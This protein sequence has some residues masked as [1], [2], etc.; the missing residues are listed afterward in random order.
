M[1][2]M[3]ARAIDTP[4]DLAGAGRGVGGATLAPPTPAPLRLAP[5]ARARLYSLTT[6][7]ASTRTYADNYV[8]QK[9]RARNRIIKTF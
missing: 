4:V 7:R 6:V 5:A 8:K 3:R 9:P 1:E 2:S